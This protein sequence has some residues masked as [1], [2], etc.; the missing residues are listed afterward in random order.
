MSYRF[1]FEAVDRTFRDLTGINKPFGG[2]IVVLGG[3]FRQILPVVIRGTRSHIIDACIKSS[4]LWRYVN[5]IHL[6]INMRIQD[7]E[8][9][10]FVDYLLRIG[11]GKELVH[12]NVGEDMV[13]L[14]NDITLDDDDVKSLISEIF[15][16][17]ND[18]DKN[19]DD[20]INYI[21]DRAIL[22]TKN[23]DVDEINEQIINN[24]DE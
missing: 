16:N 22:T 13:K 10:Q 18:Y 15:G 11:E 14:Q 3:D 24:F 19:T 7:D 12:S 20:Y 17:I 23:E 21:K 8:Q 4:D 2:I 6:T 1:A 5:V 9:K